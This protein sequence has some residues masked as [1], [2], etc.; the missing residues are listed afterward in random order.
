ML[1]V[2]LC[3][4]VMIRGPAAHVVDGG[5]LEHET[6]VTEKGES[7]DHGS[8]QP[9]EGASASLQRPEY[10]VEHQG[11][12]VEEQE[13]GEAHSAHEQLLHRVRH[14]VHSVAKWVPLLAS[15]QPPQ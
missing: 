10:D 7:V 12:G 8:Q 3:F 9:V 1:L 13:D 4:E 11:G 5:R 15:E 6:S 2:N 14:R